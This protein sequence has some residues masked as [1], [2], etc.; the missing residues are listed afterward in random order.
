MLIDKESILRQVPQGLD[1]RQLLFLDGIRVSADICDLSIKRLSKSLKKLPSLVAY[2]E[3]YI[4]EVISAVQDAWAVIDSVHRFRELLQQFHGIK[5]NLPQFQAFYRS[6]E[7]AEEF[8]HFIQHIRREV[9]DLSDH[10]LPLWGTITWQLMSDFTEGKKI[11]RWLHIGTFYEG[12][13]SDLGQFHENCRYEVDHIK[14]TIGG[15]SVF[16]LELLRLM[17]PILKG[18]EQDIENQ[19]GNLP[20]NSSDMLFSLELKEIHDKVT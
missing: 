4:T 12:V 15:R 7:K 6:S 18:F 8:R 20:R 16:L 14:L 11:Q 10:Q 13:R 5:K 17:E 9:N 2:S 3:D 19:A 1:K